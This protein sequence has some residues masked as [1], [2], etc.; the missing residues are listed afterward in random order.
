MTPIPGLSTTVWQS[1]SSRIIMRF[2]RPMER[3]SDY[4]NFNRKY[5]ESL[6]KN[7]ILHS[8]NNGEQQKQ[9]M[10]SIIRVTK[11]HLLENNEEKNGY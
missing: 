1:G 8:K 3:L 10:E 9:D 11:T 5:Y 7:A 6:D 4:N 2:F